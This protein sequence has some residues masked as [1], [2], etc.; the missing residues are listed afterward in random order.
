LRDTLNINELLYIIQKP[1]GDASGEF[2]IKNDNGDYRDHCDISIEVQST[3]LRTMGYELQECFSNTNAYVMA[4]EL[5]ALF[6]SQVRIM[7][8]DYM[9]KFLSIKWKRTHAY[10]VI[11]Q[12]TMR[13]IHG[14]L[15]D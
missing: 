7:K 1:L 6:A 15:T 2:M 3:M 11:W 14:C 5:E 9:D 12:P 4:V 8:C 13:R 10:R